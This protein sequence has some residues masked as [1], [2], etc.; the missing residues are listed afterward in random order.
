[1]GNKI[2]I[3]AAD[4][5]RSHSRVDNRLSKETRIR[6]MDG[7]EDPMLTNIKTYGDY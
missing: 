1:M 7:E 6:E 4:S 5:I 3:G 2:K